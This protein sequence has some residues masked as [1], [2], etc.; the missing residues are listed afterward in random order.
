MSI[1][2]LNARKIVVGAD[3]SNYKAYVVGSIYRQ[4][5]GPCILK[6]FQQNKDDENMI[7][8]YL[9]PKEKDKAMF[10]WKSVRK[11]SCLEIEYDSTPGE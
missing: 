11:D 8:L 10:L 1:K 3:W 4:P 2:I 5:T 9:K 6:G 7:D